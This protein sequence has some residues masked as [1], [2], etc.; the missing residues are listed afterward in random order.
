VKWLEEYRGVCELSEL[1]RSRI[2][3]LLRCANNLLAMIDNLG[4]EV[5]SFVLH[6]SHT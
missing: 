3:A 5:S 2:V 1:R 4:V 6:T